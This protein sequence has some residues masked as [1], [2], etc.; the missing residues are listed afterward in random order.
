MLKTT[1]QPN[2]CNVIVLKSV[3]NVV[4]MTSGPVS[5][6]VQLLAKGDVNVKKTQFS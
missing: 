4:V 2:K 5:F 1:K 6:E 3:H